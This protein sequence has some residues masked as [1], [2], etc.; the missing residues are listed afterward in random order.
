MSEQP[1]ERT[2][3]EEL[4]YLEDKYGLTR[5]EIVEETARNVA[6]LED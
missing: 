3:K 2:L 4:E 5:S 1:R 6:H